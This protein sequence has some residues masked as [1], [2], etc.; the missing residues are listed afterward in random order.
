[1]SDPPESRK[2]VAS[3]SSSS[4]CEGRAPI[5]PKSLGVETSPR[6]KCSMPDAVD[7]RAPGERVP[8]VGEPAGQRRAAGGLVAALRDCETRGQ[9]GD[10]G[11]RA[12][13]RRPRP[14][15]GCRPAAGRGRAA[16][17]PAA[18]GWRRARIR[19][20]PRR[21]ASAAAGRP[22]RR[23]ATRNAPGSDP[24]GGPARPR[25]TAASGRRWGRR[26]T[27]ARP[28]RPRRRP[29][30]G[31]SSRPGV[32][33]SN[34]WSWHRAVDG[35]ADERRHHR[36]DH[37]VAVDV[38]ADLAIDAVIANVAQRALVPR[39]GGEH[40]QGDGQARAR[41]GTSRRR[42]PAP[43]RIGRRACRG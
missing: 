12:R 36:R 32:I 16:G 33:G 41:R 1:M 23:R 5:R 15:C 4:G 11:D 28:C 2:V 21:P 35:R 43:A 38:V 24:G 13:H 40:A 3:Q 8:R 39:P 30:G 7:D 14:G 18:C 27:A 37:V 42:R 20:R 31:C 29:P 26:R 22:A 19:S 6:P 9:A 34:L 17:R 10:A 25:A